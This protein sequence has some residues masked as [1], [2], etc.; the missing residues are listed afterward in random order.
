MS[1]AKGRDPFFDN[2]K[3]LLV[4]LVALGHSWE[5]IIGG[6]HAL[7]AVHTVVYGF[8]MPAFILLS[9][10][11][12]RTFAFRPDQIRKLLSG[13]LVPYLIFTAIY[14][15]VYSVVRGGKLEFTPTVP[16]YLCW[17][18]IALFVWRLTAPL[19]QAVRY[20]VAIAVVISLAAGLVPISG[21]LALPRVLMFLPWFV[22]GLRTRP[23]HFQKLRTPLIRCCA[24]PALLLAG[25][26]GYWLAPAPD[27][28]WVS[29]DASY[30]TLNVSWYSYLALRIGLFVASGVL[31]VAFLA[32][33]PGRRTFFTALGA[34][35]MYP[36]LLHGL[37]VRAGEA[38]GIYP[39][40]KSWGLTGQLL[41]TLG[42]I[43][44]VLLLSTRPVRALARP[45]IEPRF[46]R[47]L[48]PKRPPEPAPAAREPSATRS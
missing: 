36:Y 1:I 26:I 19:W 5:Q 34:A 18:L 12:S 38:G 13:V 23:E 29:M 6:T 3:F 33:V 15:W 21:E 9:G 28:H 17:F 43:S 32:L 8:H 44:A 45:L 24:V 27:D 41:I 2:A 20:P 25:L 11:L 14:S 47:W 30:L 22:L 10:Y 16:T 4:V 40:L 48:T 35:T 46:P 42:A 7:R 39:V 37:L 31:V